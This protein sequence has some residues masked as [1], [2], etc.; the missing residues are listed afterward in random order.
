[1]KVDLRKWQAE[2]EKLWDARPI[3][4]LDR[5]G[6]WSHDADPLFGSI[7]EAIQSRDYALTVGEL[8]RISTWKLQSGRNDSNVEENTD[9]QISRRVRAA[10]DASSDKKAVDELLELS[11]VG[12]PMASTVLTMA[13]PSEFAIIDYRAFRALAAAKSNLF[14]LALYPVSAEFLEH[15]RTYLSKPDS[16]VFYMR[17]IRELADAEGLSP[18]EVDIALWALDKQKA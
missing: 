1:M 10:I 14:E 7:S 15:F 13:R 5:A 9:E 12:V 16:Y 6:E 2:F 18:R 4:Y 8:R 11:G 17:H 3:E